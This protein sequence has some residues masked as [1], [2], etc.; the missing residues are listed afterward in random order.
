MEPEVFYEAPSKPHEFRNGGYV[1]FGI[2]DFKLISKDEI[3][4][5]KIFQV[6]VPINKVNTLI[7][8][9]M[10]LNRLQKTDYLSHNQD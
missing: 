5:R 9:V 3:N 4:G 7:N 6:H 10:L 2:E 1:G 8:F